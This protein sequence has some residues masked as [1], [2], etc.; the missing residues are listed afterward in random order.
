MPSEFRTQNVTI[1][2]APKIVLNALYCVPCDQVVAS[3][4]V[5]DC[6]EC[7]GGHCFVDGGHEYMRHGGEGVNISILLHGGKLVFADTQLTDD[8]KELWENRR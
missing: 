1:E 4:T 7:A 5:H 3:G 2:R 6:R 8:L